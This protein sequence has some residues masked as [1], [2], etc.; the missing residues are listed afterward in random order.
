MFD[1]KDLIEQMVCQDDM[2]ECFTGK[3]EQCST[4]S[5]IDVLT[6][7]INFDLDEKLFLDCM[8]EIESEV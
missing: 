3:C 6:K 5:L 7:S 2:E 8:A 4:R 1:V